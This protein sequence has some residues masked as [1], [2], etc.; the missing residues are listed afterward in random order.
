M[1]VDSGGNSITAWNDDQIAPGGTQQ[2]VVAKISPAGSIVWKTVVTSG[3]TGTANPHL[4]QLS[5]GSYVVGYS[6]ST[7]TSSWQ[8]Q[9]LDASGVPQYPGNG[10][11]VAETG[12]YEGLSDI[13]PA[14][15]GFVAMWVRGSGTNPITTNKGL[16]LQK[17][18]AAGAA[19]W[20]AGAPVIVWA[21]DATHSIQNGYF[22]TMRADGA[23]G[24]VV[25]W[26]E[27]SGARNAYIQ[28]VLAGGALK[29]ASPVPNSVNASRIRIGAGLA[30]NTS[31]G[32]YY[33][34]STESSTPTQGNYG[35]IAQKF[36][37]SGARQWTD[38]GATVLAANA[39]GQ[40]SF[41]QCQVMGDGCM[42]FFNDTRTATTRVVDSARIDGTGAVVWH[43]LVNSDSSNDKSRLTSTLSTQG[44]AILAYGWGNSG[45]VDIAAQN[46]NADGSLG[47]QAPCYA[48][49]DGSTVAPALNANDF[50]C[51]LNKFAASDVYANCD[52][53]TVAPVLNANDFQC[54]L[55]AF[56]I[57]CP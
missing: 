5:D 31:T 21:G 37:A 36:D 32:E 51:F 28:H 20:N 19:Q 39:G 2:V 35:L 16:Y 44:F 14:G 29:F 24:V 27:T 54:F 41:E 7:S 1:I 3:T 57:G 25:G 34:C 52:G 40:P 42:V 23:G 45:S 8:F 50:Q 22:P 17:Y 53:S 30:Y 12:H 9:R 47:Y 10:I 33:L 38:N 49:C 18:D 55:N 13:K 15:A 4:A 43:N 26:Y 6:Y 46:V 48:N 56:A 11:A